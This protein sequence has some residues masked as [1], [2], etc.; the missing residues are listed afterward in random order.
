MKLL[1]RR[2]LLK[3]VIGIASLS[4]FSRN[5]IS[6]I[7][8]PSAMEGPFYPNES[9]RLADVDN[10]L[11]KV[12]GL[13]KQAGGEIILLKGRVMSKDGQPLAEHRIEI[14]QCD[15]NGRYLHPNDVQ[16]VMYD[17]GF[18]G[19]GHDITDA[20]GNYSFITIKPAI[21]S[22][23]APHIHV[24]LFDGQNEILTTQLYIAGDANNNTDS[25]YRKMSVKQ[26]KQVSMVFTEHKNVI[27]TNIDLIV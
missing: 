25:L 26:A 8:T 23:R 21:Y 13:V 5:A 16:S 1:T 2:G 14:W 22:G 15:V 9:M 18:Q 6:A 11:V 3:G 10:D 12:S 4:I 24:K 27:E 17:H 20:N 7:L 19:F